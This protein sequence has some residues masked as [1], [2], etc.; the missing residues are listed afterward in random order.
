MRTQ[1]TTKS[2]ENN[3]GNNDA[4][5]NND[6]NDEN[7]KSNRMKGDAKDQVKV[8]QEDVDKYTHVRVKM[9]SK[10]LRIKL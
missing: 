4:D 7:D 9:N 3:S 1:L 2:I 8:I 10:K 6:N 5:D